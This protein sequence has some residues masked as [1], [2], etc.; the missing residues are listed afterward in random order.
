MFGAPAQRPG[1]RRRP[2]RPPADARREPARL[3]RQP[4]HRARHARPA[5]AASAS[6]AARSWWSTRAARAPPR[7]PTSTTSS[8]P[9]PTPTCCSRIVHTLFEEGLV[10]PGRSR[11]TVEG[12][13]EVERARCATSRPRPWRAACGHRGR[14]DPP[15]GARARRAPSAPPSTGGSAPAPRSSARSRAGSSTCST[16][17]PATSTARAARCSRRRPPA[18]ATRAATP[19]SGKGVRLGRWQSRV[20]GLP[21]GLRRAAGRVPGRGDRHARRGPGP[22]AGHRRGQPGGVARPNSGRLERG[23]RAARLHGRA[24]TST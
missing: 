23:A 24:S 7:R 22:G 17:S 2:H 4:A 8:G 9:A 15:H 12:L 14:G 5:A 19:G 16:C 20:R 13:D 18:S 6:A 21:R 1:P 11:S 10:D 3:E